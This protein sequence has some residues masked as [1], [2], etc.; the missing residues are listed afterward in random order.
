METSKRDPC[1]RVIHVCWVI[2]IL[3]PNITCPLMHLLYQTSHALSSGSFQK[4]TLCLFSAKHSLIRQFPEKT[5]QDITESPRK[6]E[7]PT[8][9]DVSQ[10]IFLF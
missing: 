3:F 1:Q 2:L 4:N 5:P 7:I 10:N 9:C 8:S 6:P